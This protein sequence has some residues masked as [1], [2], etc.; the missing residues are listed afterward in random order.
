M[1]NIS[2]FVNFQVVTD[3]HFYYLQIIMAENKGRVGA[4]KSRKQAL[5]PVTKQWVKID[6]KS[7]KFM[8]VKTSGGTFKGVR[9]DK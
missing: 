3:C 8:D 2:Y 4:V 6:T 9:K 5:N 7:G 1:T